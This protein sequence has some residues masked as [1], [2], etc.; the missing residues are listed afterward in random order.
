MAQLD[1]TLDR[2]S[3]VPLGTQLAWKLRGAVSTGAL[4][5]GDRLPGVRELAEAAA[6][7]VN[8]VRAVY[9]R[10]AEQGVIVSEHGRGT[11]AAHDR[12]DRAGV[13]EIVERA[14]GEARRLG[15]DPRELA[16]LLYADAP[17]P[18]TADVAAR[19]ALR[20]EIAALEHELAELDAQLGKLGDRPAASHRRAAST[21]GPRV[22]GAAEL[23]RVRDRLA[24]Q[25]SDRRERLDAGRATAAAAPRE[26]ESEPQPAAAGSPWPELLFSRRPAPGSA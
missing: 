4:Q 23:E 11:F 25:V 21:R 7:N 24:A 1:L 26:P 12:A 3:D 15:V 9:A 6:V 13:R 16:A 14:A 18:A 5:P 22:L 20:G 19:R 10:L 8:T 17:P 2:S